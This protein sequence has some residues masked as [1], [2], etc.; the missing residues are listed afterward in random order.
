M[1]QKEIQTGMFRILGELGKDRIAELSS[2]AKSH[3]VYVMG[4]AT[5]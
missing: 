3:H 1:Y 2:G 4:L 5:E